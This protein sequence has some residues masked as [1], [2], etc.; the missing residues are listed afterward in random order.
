VEEIS[1]M[2]KFAFVLALSLVVAG[3]SMAIEPEILLP[4]PGGNPGGIDRTVLWVDVPDFAANTGSSEIIGDYALETEIANDF[5]LETPAVV[6]KVTW[7]G[8]YWND[9][10]TNWPTGAGFNIRF[11]MDAGC[12]PEDVPFLEYLLP[13]DDCCEAYADGGDMFSQYIY[14][15]CLELALDP[16]LYWFSVQMASHGF[17]PQWGRLG[18][19]MTQICDSAF[20]S[21]YFSFPTW[22]PAPDVFGDLYDASQMFEDECIPTATENASW[23]AIKGLYR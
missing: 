15:F 1:L 20:R 2:K 16:N 19:D 10:G 8:A 7:W 22:V 12:L 21:D 4:G 13:E 14:E 17:P 23:G 3:S 6:M 9:D 11:Y 18:A 5:I